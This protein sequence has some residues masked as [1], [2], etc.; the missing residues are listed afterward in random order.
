MKNQSDI[1]GLNCEI[2]VKI[3]IL[4]VSKNLFQHLRPPW[5]LFNF[6]FSPLIISE[7]RVIEHLD[8]AGSFSA[9]T[10]L[11]PVICYRYLYSR[12][13][14]GR[15]GS[16]IGGGRRSRSRSRSR[17][18]RGRRSRSRERRSGSRG[19]KKPNEGGRSREGRSGRY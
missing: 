1:L 16:G 19:Y 12:R 10:I 2:G 14:G 15:A 6:R 3:D 5:C 13:K 18:P 7:R 8:S 11:E 9:R 4:G 17:G